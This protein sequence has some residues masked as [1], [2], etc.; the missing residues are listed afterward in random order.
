MLQCSFSFGVSRIQKIT[1]LMSLVCCR[2]RDD[3]SLYTLTQRSS[4]QKITR[5]S[6]SNLS[7]SPSLNPSQPSA[8]ILLVANSSVLHPTKIPFYF[9]RN[10]RSEPSSNY[11]Y[12][13]PH[14]P[15]LCLWRQIY[16]VFVCVL[17]CL[18][19]LA[20]QIYYRLTTILYSVV[21]CWMVLK[22]HHQ[23]VFASY[24]QYCCIYNNN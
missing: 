20:H 23:L 19:I 11:I 5:L 12:Y 9:Y 22:L 3:D 24:C 13:C 6:A 8:T 18:D 16:L 21:I 15:I 1:H 14:P 2:H 17:F 7:P 10:F 4:S